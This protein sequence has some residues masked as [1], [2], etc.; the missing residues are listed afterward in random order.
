MATLNVIIVDEND[1]NPKFSKPFYRKSVVENS[2]V[3]T[4]ILN[5]LANDADKN[6]T[7]TYEIEGDK[8]FLDLIYLDSESGE[9][10]VR[11]KIDHEIF[12]WLNFS[13]RAIDSGIPPRS[14]LA[15]CFIKVID[16]NDNNPIFLTEFQNLTIYEN[17]PIGTEIAVIEAND[18]DSDDYGKIT[19]LI[20]RL[21]S[22]GKFAIDPDT[23]VLKIIDNIDREK[24]SSYIIVIEIWD[25]YQFGAAS[26]ESRNAFKQF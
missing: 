26:G 23:G 13:V 9:I 19:F 22:Q 17:Q 2:P 10:V 24:K 5:V 25:N 1:N 18:A 3:G 21:S 11:D 6:K 7:V 8:D 16:E 20:D 4:P 15:E 14:S 12:Q